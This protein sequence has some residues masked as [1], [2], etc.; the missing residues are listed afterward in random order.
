MCPHSICQ[1]LWPQGQLGKVFRLKAQKETSFG[2]QAVLCYEAWL[3]H[4]GAICSL[5]ILVCL[6]AARWDRPGEPLAEGPG[7]SAGSGALSSE[8][9]VKAG[10]L[11]RLMCRC[12][13]VRPC[14]SGVS[15]IC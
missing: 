5:R 9:W 11:P 15:N 14:T 13:W 4:M 10:L 6:L 7:A 12:P 3:G 2:E 1:D 8:G